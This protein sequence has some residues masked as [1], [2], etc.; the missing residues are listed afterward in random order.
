MMRI[1]TNIVYVFAMAFTIIASCGSNQKQGDSQTSA[2]TSKKVA[3]PD[4]P[5]QLV[6]HVISTIN[7]GPETFN[8][9]FL[10]VNDFNQLKKDFPDLKRYYDMWD[11]MD[12][13]DPDRFPYSSLLRMF[14]LE[15][16]AAEMNINF[17][18]RFNEFM[19]GYY[20]MMREGAIQEQW[21]W[22]EIRM[23]DCRHRSEDYPKV[24]FVRIFNEDGSYQEVDEDQY[25]LPEIGETT[26]YI[27]ING[28]IEEWE[29]ITVKTRDGWRL[30]MPY[31]HWLRD[32]MHL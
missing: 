13:W 22:D 4:D 17:S 31:L 25:S 5:C 21:I 16:K 24:D 28:E 9:A 1:N 30:F 3:S 19:K 11:Q 20:S 2:K 7:K 18:D 10:D 14:F 27:I 6:F 15:R 32:E 8:E 12:T 26:V 29:F 23:N